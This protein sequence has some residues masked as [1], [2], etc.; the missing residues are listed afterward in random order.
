MGEVDLSGGKANKLAVAALSFAHFVSDSYS[1][2]VYPLLPLLAQRLHLSE[3]EVFTLAPVVAITSSV[4]QPLYGFLSDRYS[5]RLFAVIGPAVTGCFVSLIGVAPSYGVLM[6]LLFMGGV[7]VGAFHPQAVSL[8]A[9]SSGA[10]RRLG[11]SI[12]AS[13][14]TLGFAFGP[15]I[16]GLIV[17]ATDLSKTYYT[18]GLGLLTTAFLYK[19][20]P[21]IEPEAL[22]RGSPQTATRSPLTALRAART[23]LLILYGIAVGR[24]AMQMMMGNYIPFILKGQGYSIESIGGVLTTYLLAG[25]V[26]SFV[27]GALAERMSGRVLTV[28][29]GVSSALLLSVGFLA[30]GPLGIGLMAAGS[31]ALISVVPVNIAM[32][33]ELCPGHTSTV[34]ALLMGCAWGLGSLAAP[35]AEPLAS[36]IGFRYVLVL[37]TL[38][39][40][41]TSLPAL[42]LPRDKHVR[43]DT[44]KEVSLAP[45]GD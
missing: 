30:Q 45:S 10:Y 17:G 4:M 1:S 7:G 21:R 8:T 40:L 27:G 28:S 5:R 20:C 41:L 29:T 2:T 25:A 36:A 37:A 15:L 44:V 14:G 38:L 24:A 16:I 22:K 31:F 13:A 33:Q 9:R 3:L 12:F 6:G 39:P 11:V 43:F 26:G 34:S 35:L 23:P 19:F 18:I 42:Y 32:A